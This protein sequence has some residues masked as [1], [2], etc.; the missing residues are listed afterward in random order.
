[1]L[2]LQCFLR[3][4]VSLGQDGRNYSLTDLK[5]PLHWTAKRDPEAK[6]HFLQSFLRKGVSLGHVE[7]NLN[8][9]DQKDLKTWKEELKPKGLS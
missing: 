3:K 4:G 2:Y 1:M 5:E 6:I 7:K 8:L 9:K